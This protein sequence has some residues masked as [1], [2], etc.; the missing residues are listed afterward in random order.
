MDPSGSGVLP[1]IAFRHIA[2]TE[3]ITNTFVKNKKRPENV[4]VH[5]MCGYEHTDCDIGRCYRRVCPVTAHKQ[6]L[7]PLQFLCGN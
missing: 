5:L 7:H 1:S 3:V 6:H 4:D 2:A